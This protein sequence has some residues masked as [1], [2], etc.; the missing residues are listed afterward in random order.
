MT[1]RL[2]PDHPWVRFHQAPTVLARVAAA[3][4]LVALLEDQIRR[5]VADLRSNRTPWAEIGR[6]LG[7]TGQSASRR[8]GVGGRS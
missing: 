6:A 1:E 7:V 5:D 4:A 2:P 3:A 8:F